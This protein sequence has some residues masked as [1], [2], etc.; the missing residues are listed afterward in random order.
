M[1]NQPANDHTLAS[2]ANLAP[3]I[4]TPPLHREP[5]GAMTDAA[6]VAIRALLAASLFSR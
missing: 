2:I 5:T 1:H 4:V 3:V 6:L